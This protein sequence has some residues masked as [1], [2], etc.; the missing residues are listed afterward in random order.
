MIF[1][2]KYKVEEKVWVMHNNKPTEATIQCVIASAWREHTHI[3]YEVRIPGSKGDAGNVSGNH[4]FGEC[5][6][7]KDRKSLIA[8]L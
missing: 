6:L 5:L 1:R 7:F 4:D 3:R 2:T 8:S